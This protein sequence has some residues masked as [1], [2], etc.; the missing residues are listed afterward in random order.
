MQL[1]EFAGNAGGVHVLKGDTKQKRITGPISRNEITPQKY[2]NR[3]SFYSQ[4]TV[5]I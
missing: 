1:S 5:K 3:L 4:F 2:Q